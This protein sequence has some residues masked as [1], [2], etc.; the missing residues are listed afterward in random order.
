M[1]YKFLFY[2]IS[3]F[4]KKVDPLGG[5]DEYCYYAASAL[6]G[7][8]MAIGLNVIVNAVCIFFCSEQKCI[9]DNFK[10]HGCSLSCNELTIILIF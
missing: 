3:W 2:F 4:N 7:F 5:T 1:I 6:V 9:L 8:T 10:H